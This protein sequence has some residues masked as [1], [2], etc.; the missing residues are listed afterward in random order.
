MELPLRSIAI[1]FLLLPEGFLFSQ[2]KD[3]V[4]Q[5]EEESLDYYEKWLGQDVV[6]IISPEEREV[7]LSLQAPEEKEQFIEQ[8]WFRRDPDPSSAANEYKEEHYRR[9]AYANDRFTSG[10]PGWRTDRGRIYIIHGEPAEIE[11]H[12]NVGSYDRPLSE[13]GGSTTAFPFEIWRYREIEGLGTDIQIEFVDPTMSGEYRLAERHEEKD[14]LMFTP[15]TGLTLAEQQGLAGRADRPFFT[16]GN[17]EKYPYMNRSSRDNPF[18]RYEIYTKIQGPVSVKYKDLKEMVEVNVAYD[19][20]PFDVRPDYINLNPT[21]VLVPLTVQLENRD[22]MFQKEKENDIQRAELAVYGVVSTMSNRVVTEFED[23]LETSFPSTGLPSGLLNSSI[24][25]KVIV[26]ERGRRYKLDLVVKDLNSSQVGVQRIAVSPP[27]YIDRGLAASSLILSDQVQ[28]LEG[29]PGADEMF[30][31]GDVK[32]LPSLPKE[33][34]AGK[35]LGVYFQ[36]YNLASD[37]S[38]LA[39]SVSTQFDLYR[40]GQLT[41]RIIDSGNQSIQYFSSDRAVFIKEISLAGFSPGEYNLKVKVID[42]L[43]NENLSLSEQFSVH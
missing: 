10:I 42:K 18:T 37:Q 27:D 9:I 20:L 23:D 11:S 25:Q 17:R 12:P 41:E 40:D 43:K 14:A 33:F 7:F 8:F 2:D 28:I 30:V 39:P 4:K 22:L 21:H 3:T 34:E 15:G 32:I 13:G 31:I 19:S 26:L 24:Y 29:V 5:L 35:K 36:I 6:Y 1:L 38:T 16:P